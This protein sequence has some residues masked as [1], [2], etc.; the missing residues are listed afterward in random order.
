MEPT[1]TVSSQVD[2]PARLSF[3]Q[4][5]DLFGQAVAAVIT[6]ALIAAPLVTPAPETALIPAFPIVAAMPSP[7]VVAPGALR[8]FAPASLAAR[9]FRAYESAGTP[10]PTAGPLARTAFAA[11]IMRV[12]S[13]ATRDA[14]RK[15]LS[16]RLTGWLTGSGTHSVRP[17]PTVR[18][19]AP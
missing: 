5:R 7:L 15:T 9:R 4:K 8:E 3:A 19:E 1:C 14:P 18:A 2:A 11:S 10:V 13:S 6:T 12:G 16:R 17:F